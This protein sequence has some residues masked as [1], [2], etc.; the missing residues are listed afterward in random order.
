MK[1]ESIITLE[2]GFLAFIIQ[3]KVCV[4]FRFLIFLKKYEEKKAHN[5]FFFMLDL[6][7]KNLHLVASFI[8]FEQNKVI[9]E[10]KW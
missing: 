8:G 9:V 4:G 5:M 1:E 10:K 7:F 6:R 3:K 2:L